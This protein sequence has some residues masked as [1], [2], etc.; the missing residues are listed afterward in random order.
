MNVAPRCV[1][2]NCGRLSPE[3]TYV[4]LHERRPYEWWCWKCIEG[5]SKAGPCDDGNRPRS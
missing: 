5:A 4:Q 1:C 3:C 2:A